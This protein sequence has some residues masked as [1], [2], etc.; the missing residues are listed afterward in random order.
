[1]NN[2]ESLVSGV[3]ED[4]EQAKKLERF[5]EQMEA[6]YGKEGE[7]IASGSLSVAEEATSLRDFPQRVG[8]TAPSQIT[9]WIY[10][11]GLLLV[12]VLGGALIWIAREKSTAAVGAPEIPDPDT[13]SRQL[14]LVDTSADQVLM[15]EKVGGTSRIL[16]Q[17]PDQPGWLL[18]SLDDPNATNPAL[19]ADSSVVAYVSAG[20]EI[21]VVVVPLSDKD[22]FVITEDELEDVKSGFTFCGWTPLALSPDA[23][24]IAF[25]ACGELGDLEISQ[26]FVMWLDGAESSIVAVPGSE[27][28]VTPS[29]QILWADFN[30]LIMDFS[31]LDNHSLKTLEVPAP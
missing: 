25:F 26:A 11:L 10:L 12:F 14:H 6:K 2:A 7:P 21:Q 30:H 29:R 20:D 27:S 19:A 31:G 23:N 22:R 16:I 9:P 24:A 3:S 8:D 4:N 17:S 28:N 13:L 1:M 5:R 18:V 15:V